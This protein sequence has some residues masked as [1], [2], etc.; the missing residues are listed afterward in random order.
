MRKEKEEHAAVGVELGPD[1]VLAG[2]HV[3]DT[4]QC[5]DD[6]RC[7]LAPHFCGVE[8]DSETQKAITHRCIRSCDTICR[9][10]ACRSD[11]A[12]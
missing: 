4:F 5:T 7:D 1:Q 6:R 11:M 9:E 12:R 3:P 8:G 2:A 10:A